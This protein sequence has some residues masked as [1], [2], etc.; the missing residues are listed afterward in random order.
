MRFAER[1]NTLENAKEL[2]ELN[3]IKIYEI[4]VLWS[5]NEGINTR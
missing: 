3:N 1:V 2:I 4:I 5:E